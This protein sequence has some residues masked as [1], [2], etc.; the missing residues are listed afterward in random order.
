MSRQRLH[1]PLLPMEPP[2]GEW[3]LAKGGALVAFVLTV[4]TLLL[5]LA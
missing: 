1:G 2:E 3:P 4:A 5:A